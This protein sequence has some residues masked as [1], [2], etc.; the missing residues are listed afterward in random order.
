[1]QGKRDP[2]ELA[3]ALAH[4]ARDLLTQPSVQDTLDRIGHHA[5]EL[6]DGC[7]DAGILVLDGTRVRTLSAT[8]S[9]V[10]HSDRLQG[11]C[12]EGPCFDAVRDRQEVYR[13]P[14][15]TDTVDRW[16]RFAPKARD[17]GIGSMMGFLLF[18]EDERYGA[19]DLYSTDPDAFNERSEQ[20]GWLLASHAAVAL[21]SAQHD[22][23]LRDA[24]AT[25]QEIGEAMGILMERY[26]ISERQAFAVLVEAS[27]RQNTKL[28]EIAGTVTA[29]G[30]L[31]GAR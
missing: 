10:E 6:V 31:P 21:A 26:K 24:I 28:R 22:A 25:R 9:L 16:P 14:D 5:T 4:M 18:T 12:G 27:Q 29:T 19:L 1:M 15:M 13:I 30:E 8:S 11:E 23:Q 2:E 7:T 20:V 3:T 17:L